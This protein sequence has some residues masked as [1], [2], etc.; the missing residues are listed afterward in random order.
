MNRICTTLFAI[1]FGT[2]V[3]FAE[4]MLIIGKDTKVFETTVAKD[5]Y[6]AVNQN[7][8]PVI[9]RQGMTFG[10]KEKK[11]GWYVVEYSSGLRGMV[12]QNVVADD[13][14]VKSPVAGTYKVTNNPTETVTI[15]N[16]GSTWNLTSGNKSF[17]GATSGKSVT[18]TNTDGNVVYTLVN[19]SG[20][21]MV[22]N[23]NNSVTRFF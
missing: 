23:Y 10:I 14:T 16:N 8:E 21:P 13:A 1:F 5:E 20:K 9:L 17:S 12:M 4:D 7:D 3:M 18:F 22:Y 2:T 11:A 6:A 15:T 19:I